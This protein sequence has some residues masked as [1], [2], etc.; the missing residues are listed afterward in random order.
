MSGPAG[1]LHL[2]CALLLIFT[3]TPAL[4]QHS[5]PSP[6][7]DYALIYGTVWGPDNF[8]AAGIPVK[9]RVASEKKWKWNLTSDRRGEFAQRVPA[10]E[11]DYVIQADIKEPKGKAKPETTVHISGNERQD[12]GL[13]LSQEE[14]SS[15]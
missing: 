14:L 7:K 13:H 5:S 1:P 2:C 3:A 9:I 10:G 6:Q 11:Q 8:P 15:R 4:P 12:V